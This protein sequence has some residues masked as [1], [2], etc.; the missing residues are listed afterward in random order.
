MPTSIVGAGPSTAPLSVPSTPTVFVTPPTN[1][2]LMDTS[3]PE[4]SPASSTSASDIW[5]FMRPLSSPEQPDVL[6]GPHEPPRIYARPKTK[7]VGCQLCKKWQVCTL[8]NINQNLRTHLARVHG[9]DWVD[10]VR[11]LGLKILETSRPSTPSVP[12]HTTPPPPPL[13]REELVNLLVDWV[14]ADDE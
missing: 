13:R 2:P 7:Y 9:T 12:D 14:T 11:R 10:E 5:Y 1:T 4:R 3:R 6:P 8:G